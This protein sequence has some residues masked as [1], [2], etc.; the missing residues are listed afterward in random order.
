MNETLEPLRKRFAELY[1]RS[2]AGAVRAPGRVNLIGEH[3][4]YNDG[5]VLPIAIEKRTAAVYAPGAGR[6]VRLASVQQPGQDAVIDL[7]GRIVKGEPKWANYCR[8]VAAGLAARG[9]K[10]AACDVLFDS[11]VPIG[12]GLSSSASL[13]VATA[14][15][16]LGSAGLAGAVPPYE[17]A[18]LCQKAEHDYAGTPCGIMDQAIS[19]MGQA[20]HALLLDC[21]DGAVRQVPFDDPD[22]VLL[23]ADTQVKHDLTDGG[24]AARRAQCHSAAAKLGAASLREVDGPAVAAAGAAGKLDAKE[25]MRARHV[26]GEIERTVQSVEALEAHDYAR[27]GGLMVGSHESLRDDYEVSCEELDAIVD[28]ALGQRGVFGARMT[29]GGFGGC[30]IVLVEAARADAASQA[31][32]EGFAK[33]FGRRCPV[34]ATHAAAGAGPIG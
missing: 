25:I 13:E 32:R 27:F 24:Y 26:V 16:L 10:L 1:G 4:D 17:L 2:P 7:D 22:V 5:F 23:V 31:V 20:G 33:R 3:T 9:L 14:L 8:G 34:F 11:D 18:K 29:G 21:R 12:G 19:V 28:L 15:A 30:A 6:R